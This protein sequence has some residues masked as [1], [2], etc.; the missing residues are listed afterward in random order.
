MEK[1]HTGLDE[2]SEYATLVLWNDY[3]CSV[4]SHVL[5]WSQISIFSQ[6][7]CYPNFSTNSARM[8]GCYGV[9]FRCG[10]KWLKIEIWD[11]QALYGNAMY[12]VFLDPSLTYP[13]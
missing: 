4:M 13:S 10:W 11:L 1:P 9:K 8:L 3:V 7:H 6:F 5:W 12:L 2:L